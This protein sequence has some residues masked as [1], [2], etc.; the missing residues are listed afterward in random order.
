MAF[1]QVLH[2]PEAAYRRD[3][4][5]PSYLIPL[6]ILGVAFTLISAAQSPYHI[7]WMQHQLESSG[8]PA[9]QVAG[10]MELLRR[11]DAWR[12]VGVPLLLLLR[13]VLFALLLWL[14]AQLVLGLLDFQHALTIV[15]FSYPPLLLRD[16]V[17]CL[18]VSLRPEE[19]LLRPDGLNVAL[20]LNLLFPAIPLPW[21]SL[22]GNLNLFEAWFV[23]LLVEGVAKVTDSRRRRALAVVLP[24]WTFSAL[25][26]LGLASLGQ[27]M[28]TL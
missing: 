13:W 26:Q 11:S 8:A 3:L 20:G 10:T 21:S 24:C 18:V 1:L 17:V 28:A 9:E 23:L 7:R 12:A 2:A 14:A 5:G 27:K 6:L 15:G 25:A 19:V 22:A 16:S 4:H